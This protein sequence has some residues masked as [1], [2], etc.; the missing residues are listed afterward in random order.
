MNKENK[1]KNNLPS[2]TV[3]ELAKEL[4]SKAYQFVWICETQ[5]ISYRIMKKA[6]ITR[7][8]TINALDSAA[9]VEE[10]YVEQWLRIANQS[11]AGF[12]F[13]EIEE[14][15]SLL[16]TELFVNDEEINDCK[17]WLKTRGIDPSRP[18]ICIQ[19]GN[20]RT[21]RP[22]KVDRSS[23]TKYWHEKNWSKLIDEIMLHLP[24]AQVLFCGIPAEHELSLSIKE[25]CRNQK[26]IH[27]LADDLPMRRLLALLSIAHSC[28][29]VDTGPAH[30][31]AALNCPLTVLFG[32][33][34]TRVFRPVSSE[35]N[36]MIVAGRIPGIELQSGLESWRLAHDISLITTDDV[37][38]AWLDSIKP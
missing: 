6:G 13:P 33:A 28:I 22:G 1:I 36:V 18:L 21:M 4:R 34:D 38:S 15:D 5:K 23:N 3:E 30:A 37:F 10:H 16:N 9:L 24:D 35:S 7:Q 11:P 20:K 2:I 26:Q 8:T 31:A 32:K 25:L 17:T 19:A 14:D 27:S 29:S 12:D